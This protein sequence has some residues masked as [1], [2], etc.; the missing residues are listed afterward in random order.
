[1]P[2][3]K[4]IYVKE[5]PYVATTVT[6][7]RE[8]IFKEAN[9]ADILLGAILFWEGATM[10]LSFVLCYNARPHAPDYYSQGQEYLRMHEIN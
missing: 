6:A 10:V 8:P 3:L 1:M 9:S 7:N 2:I 4:H 5:Y